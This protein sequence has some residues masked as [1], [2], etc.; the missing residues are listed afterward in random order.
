MCLNF[1]AAPSAPIITRAVN[2]SSTSILVEWSPPS[3]PNGVI[4]GYQIIYAP[5]ND[6]LGNPLILQNL[7]SNMTQFEITELNFF[8]TYT[9]SV[10]ALTI[11]LGEAS[12]AVNVTTDEDGK[13]T[14]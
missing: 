7:S 1:F 4:R 8:T 14:V 3:N 13:W 10:K 5:V 12:D 11:V 6:P 2:T 9:I